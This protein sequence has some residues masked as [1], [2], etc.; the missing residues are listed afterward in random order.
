MNLVIFKIDGTCNIFIL[1]TKQIEEVPPRD[2]IWYYYSFYDGTSF[3]LR[4]RCRIVKPTGEL[5]VAE[6]VTE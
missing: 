2:E 6:E 1:T 5:I 3:M 4:N